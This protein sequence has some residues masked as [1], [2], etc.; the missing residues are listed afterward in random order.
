MV[1]GASGVLVQ[2]RDAES[3]APAGG[4]GRKCTCVYKQPRGDVSRGRR[5][6]SVPVGWF[7]AGE[8]KL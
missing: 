4:A 5:S 3:D 1:L 7:S 8:E 2:R 6:V